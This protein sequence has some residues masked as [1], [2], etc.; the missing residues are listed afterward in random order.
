M[1]VNGKRIKQHRKEAGLTQEALGKKLGVIKQTISSWENGI[2]EP[3]SEML[4][5][6][7]SIFNVPTDYL[8]GLSDNLIE[9]SD[10]NWKYPPASNRLGNIMNTYRHRNSLTE[11]EFSQKLNISQ[12]LYRN[13]EIGK[14]EP[15]LELLKKIANETHYD[16]DYLTGAT[17]HISILTD[18]TMAFPGGKI[19]IYI[20]EGNSHFKT[21]L[22]E[23]CLENSINQANVETRLGMS[24]QDFIDIQWNRMPTLSELLKISYAF[25]V[26]LDYLIGKTDIKLSSLKGDEL[27]LI[28]N[29]RDCLEHFKKSISDR[30]RDLSLE[31]LH[32]KEAIVAADAPLMKMTGT[33]NLGK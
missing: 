8:L 24:K 27:E 12:D 28:L 6:I 1:A 16:I 11:A 19:P 21:R 7:A 9:S 32:E 15:T 14:Y 31:S 29:Y 33:D 4:T 23:L 5:K 20:A 3:N 2:S 17:D 13:I 26:S 18:E 22:E 25:G 10:L 30:A